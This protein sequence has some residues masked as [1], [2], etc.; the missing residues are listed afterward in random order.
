MAGNVW[1][2]VEDC[3]TPTHADNPGDGG[4]VQATKDPCEKRVMRGGAWGDFGSFYLRTAYRGAWDGNQAFA[5]VGFR[6]A[7]ANAP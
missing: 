1:E 3:Y 6:V 4:P 7:R 5:N 2:W